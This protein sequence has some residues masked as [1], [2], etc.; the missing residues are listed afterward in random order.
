MAGLQCLRRLWRLVHEPQDYAEPPAGSPIAIG[1][2]I[3]RHAHELFPG[4]VLL[5]E[6]P[7]QHAEAV[8]RTR[9]LMDDPAI[10]AIFEAAFTHDD[11]RVRVDVLERLPGGWGLREVKSS[12]RVKDHYLDDAALQLHVLEGAGLAVLSV[13]VIHVD[14]TYIRGQ[15]EVEWSAF[16]ARTDV[17]DQVRER[18]AD[19]L[20]RLPTLRACLREEVPPLVAPAGHCH[21]PYGCEFW[22]DCTADKPT[23]WIAY[24]PRL[25]AERR[26]ELE[27]LGVEAI[28][29]IP[30]E[31][32]LT[33]KQTI[34]R[35]AIVSGQPYVAADLAGQ[36]RDFALPAYYLDFEA[37][38]PPIPL[39]PGTW[40]YQTIPFQWSLHVMDHDGTL[41]HREFL[42]AGDRDPRRP[43]AETLIAALEQCPGPVLVYSAYEQTRLRE[44]AYHLPDLAPGLQAIIGRLRDL[45][46]IVRG[47]VYFPAFAFSNSIKAVAPALCPEFGYDDLEGVADGSAAAGAFLQLSSGAVPCSE[48]ADHLRKALLAYCERDTLAMVEVHRALMRIASET[49]PRPPASEFLTAAAATALPPTAAFAAPQVETEMHDVT[50]LEIIDAHGRSYVNSAAEGLTLWVQDGGRTLKIFCKGHHGAGSATR[51]VPS[52]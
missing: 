3:G 29:A 49:E 52:S 12:T 1:F 22:A 14:N 18:Q 38:M 37:M 19:L 45:L 10:P 8:A 9:A 27:A 16:F 51:D 44:L 15:G 50:R 30:P 11:I 25:K 42:A 6:E 32:P 36:L 33:W 35:D 20:A 2:D 39:Y 26:Q 48:T 17:G 7:W 5:T 4:G 47:S 28:S 24:M 40:P 46:P 41:R 31:F 21:S 34:I 43:F 13:E 23:D